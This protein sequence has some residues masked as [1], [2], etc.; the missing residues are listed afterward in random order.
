M[1][2]DNRKGSFNLKAVVRETGLKPDALR[3]WERRYGIPRPERT[4]GGHRLYSQR[5]ID[6]LRWLVARQSEG[7]SISRA[8]DLWRKLEADGVDPLES[9]PYASPESAGAAS[10][11]TAGQTM[12]DLRQA[13]MSACRALDERK[14]EQALTQAFA[15][16]PPETV[17]LEVLRQGL[18]EIGGEWYQ[19]Q[20]TVQQEHFASALAVRRIE[21]LLLGAPPPTRR[22]R[23]LVACPSGE[24]HTFSPLLVSFLLRRRGWEVTYLGA[25][26][27]VSRMEEAVDTVNPHLVILTAQ[28]LQSAARLQ[29]MAGFLRERRVPVAYGGLV[30]ASLPEVRQRMSGHYLGDR[31]ELAVQETER[32]LAAPPP[33]PHPVPPSPDYRRALAHF[34]SRRALIEADVWRDLEAS[35]EGG[36]L[37]DA[38]RY[39]GE[40][41]QAALELGDLGFLGREIGWIEGLLVYHHIPSEALPV[42]LETYRKA[43]VAHLGEA[44]QPVLDWLNRVADGQP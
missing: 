12:N 5:D 40:D 4:P 21:A 11:Q 17:C 35:V 20:L 18:S 19:G 44:A 43:A 8:V 32:L 24:Q 15:L 39:F 27:P 3:A 38:N 13:W 26:V 1:P 2:I 29:E 6:T 7:L 28:Q 33:E 25:D 41:I 10:L 37:A 34:R 30:F 16:Y 42:Y 31:L 23:I 9:P 36:L 14:A 22:S